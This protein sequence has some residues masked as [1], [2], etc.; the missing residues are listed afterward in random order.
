MKHLLWL[1]TLCSFSLWADV[2][3]T[4]T[5]TLIPVGQIAPIPSDTIIGNSSGST[6]APGALSVLPDAIY[7]EVNVANYGTLYCDGST[8]DSATINAAITQFRTILTSS[9]GAAKLVFPANVRC[10][11]TSTL[12]FTGINSYYAVV[13]MQGMQILC[14]TSGTPCIDEVGSDHLTWVSPNVVGT[15]SNEPSIG[16]QMGRQSA[17]TDCGEQRI[18]KMKITGYFTQSALL[19]VA[20]ESSQFISAHIEN[21]DTGA[22]YAYIGD[23]INHFGLA[24]AFVTVTL[25]ANTGNSFD[26]NLWTGPIF[27]SH[28]TVP[29]IWL[30][31]PERHR[32]I[33]GYELIIG[34][35]PQGVAIYNYNTASIPTQLWFDVHIEGPGTFTD[36]FLITGPNTTPL[37]TGFTYFDHQSQ[38]ATGYFKLDTG[39]TS[40][41]MMDAYIDITQAGNAVALFE[42]PSSWTVTGKIQVGANNTTA[43]SALG[44]FNGL[45]CVG[46]NCQFGIIAPSVASPNTNICHGNGCAN[47]TGTN[48]VISGTYTTPPSISGSYNYLG[49]AHAGEGL[50]GAAGHNVIIAPNSSGSYKCNSTNGALILIGYNIDCPTTGG[51]SN[52]LNIGA[53]IAGTTNGATNPSVCHVGGE[54]ILGVLRSA[55]LN[56]TT[57]QGI[58][59]VPLTS[60]NAGY[61]ATA[62]KYIVTRIWVD[63]CSLSVTTA[64]GGIYPATSK[65]GTPLVAAAQT[66]TNCTSSTTM[67]QATLAAATTT[68]T[69]TATTLFFSLTAAQGAAAT[70]DVYVYGIPFN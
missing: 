62:T 34:S 45:Y 54:C 20:C 63:N 14:A 57:D 29:P 48:E 37:M 1:L 27:V 12:N 56:V 11:I 30:A 21:D 18:D 55:N 42:A 13:D 67:Q 43:M 35:A 3:G 24:S 25:P 50:N 58:G 69:Y 7:Q 70:G 6:A 41:T 19:N 28:G 8:D 38:A 51:V 4:T 2:T 47:V 5:G 49:G 52:V 66:Y 15:S 44:S 68:T 31:A 10:K 22:S 39:V 36:T 23:A 59:I 64:A 32:F 33:G 61:L 17:A 16:F 46:T 53:S 26:E 60:T 40:A 9:A 65:G